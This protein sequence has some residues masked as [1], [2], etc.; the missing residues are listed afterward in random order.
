M[1][2]GY[3]RGKIQDESLHYEHQ[4]HDGSYPIIGVNTFLNPNPPA[5]AE[6][7]LQRSTDDEKI[8]QLKRLRD[9]HA[10]HHDAAPAALERL[11]Q[12]VINGEN[13]FAELVE[14]VKCCSLGQIS[15]ALYQVGGQYRRTM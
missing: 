12:T 5:E 15:A 6:V 10:R 3:Q 2:T 4:K 1:E 11:R 13:V 9:F 7:V 8:N 14:A